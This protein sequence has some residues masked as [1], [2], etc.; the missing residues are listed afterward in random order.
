MMTMGQ[1]NLTGFFASR[2]LGIGI[3]FFFL[4]IIMCNLLLMNLLIALL[5]KVRNVL[6]P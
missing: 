3:V 6:R 4:Y 5:N 2:T 1:F